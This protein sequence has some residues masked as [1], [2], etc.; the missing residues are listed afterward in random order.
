[1]LL[2]VALFSRHGTDPATAFLQETRE[3]NQLSE[4]KFL[5]DQFGYRLPSPELD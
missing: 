2:D 5:V 1:M 3:K 4:A